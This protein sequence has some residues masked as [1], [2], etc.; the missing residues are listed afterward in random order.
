MTHDTFT[1][2]WNCF[3]AV[4]RL[5]S[6]F[7]TSGLSSLVLLFLPR[8][9]VC[10]RY[11]LCRNT[12]WVWFQNSQYTKSIPFPVETAHACGS[13]NN[14]WNWILKPFAKGTVWCNSRRNKANWQGSHTALLLVC[15][16]HPAPLVGIFPAQFP[17]ST[18]VGGRATHMKHTL[19]IP[20]CWW[21]NPAP[22]D[23]RLFARIYT[24]QV[25]G[26]ISSINS[27]FV[28]ISSS[29]SGEGLS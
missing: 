6:N 4:L 24:S 12:S 26:R 18:R 29:S 21:K 9:L 25:V 8:C 22:V 5:I 27:M 3:G 16:I 2:A 28:K 7:S 23:I 19:P 11:N 20:Y 1:G 14:F 10:P 15:H 17:A 13:S